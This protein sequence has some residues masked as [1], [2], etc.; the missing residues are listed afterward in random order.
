MDPLIGASLI[1]AGSKFLGGLFSGDGETRRQ[2]RNMDLQYKM[3][4]AQ[5]DRQN[6]LWNLIRQLRSGGAGMNIHRMQ[7][8][9]APQL[10]QYSKGLARS[11][12]TDSGA[13]WGG[14]GR[15]N[16]ALLQ[17]GLQNQDNNLLRMMMSL[18]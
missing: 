2:K 11:V 9:I 17:Q 15:Q 12:G 4:K 16:N 8:A 6:E 7:S 1:G 3:G 10:N 13:F 14:V 18:T 5:L